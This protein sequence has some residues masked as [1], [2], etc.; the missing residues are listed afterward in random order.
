MKLLLTRTA[1]ILV[2]VLL[3]TA[4]SNALWYA[5]RS[6]GDL[7]LRLELPT[8]ALPST[9]NSRALAL[10]GLGIFAEIADIQ[11]P[12]AYEDSL[13]HQIPGGNGTWKDTSWGGHAVVHVNFSGI[14]TGEITV[15]FNGVPRDRNLLI[16]VIQDTSLSAIEQGMPYYASETGNPWYPISQTFNSGGSGPWEDMGVILSSDELAGGVVREALRPHDSHPDLYDPYVSDPLS[17]PLDFIAEDLS[18]E[19]QPQPIP[20]PGKT[21]FT[22]ISLD[23]SSRHIVDPGLLF[24]Y[25]MAVTPPVLLPGIVVPYESSGNMIAPSV[26]HE[27]NPTVSDPSHRV[28][29][30][31]VINVSLDEQTGWSNQDYFFGTTL[32][33]EVNLTP[34]QLPVP[35]NPYTEFKV[36]VRPLVDTVLETSESS[37]V[38]DG[39]DNLTNQSIWWGIP[40]T[41]KLI[42]NGDLEYQVLIWTGDEDPEEAPMNINILDKESVLALNPLVA[43]DWSRAETL[44]DDNSDYCYKISNVKEI[45]GDHLSPQPEDYYLTAVLA[46][47]PG[48]RSFLISAKSEQYPPSGD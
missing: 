7:T 5:G 17:I 14:G 37:I 19:P 13:F 24:G 45:L 32:L 10:Q 31:S 36:I 6:S 25:K 8:T 33:P 38:F 44:Y 12:D 26:V 20:Y 43:L 30:F 39:N 15:T 4:C 2:S 27:H 34:T 29:S 40:D 18:A 42:E 41:E 47:V 3:V 11:D 1:V 9:A 23:M 35:P 21:I 22:A 16:R 48:G 46:R 28:Y